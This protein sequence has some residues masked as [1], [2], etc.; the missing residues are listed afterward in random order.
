MDV[1]SSCAGLHFNASKSNGIIKSN[2]DRHNVYDDNMDC[3]WHL[4]S[5]AKLELVFLHLETD[6]SADYVN[7][8][9]GSSSASPLIGTFSET[10]LP[11]PIM[12]SSDELY[13]TFTTDG[14]ALNSDG[15][16]ATYRGK[17]I[18]YEISHR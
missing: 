1:T 6:S 5:N 4:A 10:P 17:L 18:T 3:R 16:L 2:L 15:F 7:V 13:V 11:P 14:I 9:D 12:S 8:Y